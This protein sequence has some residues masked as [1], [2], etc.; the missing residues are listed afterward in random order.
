ME[1]VPKINIKDNILSQLQALKQ[2]V[3]RE[4]SVDSEKSQFD[5]LIAGCANGTLDPNEALKQANY[6]IDHRQDYH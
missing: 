4:G 6:I 5:M 2:R 3:L 1:H